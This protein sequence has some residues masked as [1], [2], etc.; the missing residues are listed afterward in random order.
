M[1]T[2]LGTDVREYTWRITQGT[3]ERLLIP[4]LDEAGAPF[5][6]DGW[7]VD[8]KIKDEP[9][10]V[11]LYTWPTSGIAID[12]AEVLLTIPAPVSAAWTWYAGWYRVKLTDPNSPPDNP[13][14]S[15]VLQGSIFIDLD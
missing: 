5:P 15:R 3:S 1:T 13:A 10:G 4:I 2:A 8:A 12:G 11:V 6:V 9:G 14:V 7:T